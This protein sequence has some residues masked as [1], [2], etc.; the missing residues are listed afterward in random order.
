MSYE[1]KS[2][3]YYGGAFFQYRTLF[4]GFYLQAGARISQFVTVRRANF[5][6]GDGTSLLTK[7]R[8]EY[9]TGMKPLLGA[10]YRLNERYSVELNVGPLQLKN[11]DGVAKTGTLAE[12]SFLVHL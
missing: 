10:G 3:G 12:V 11:V 7:Y 2:D 1:D 5:L 4:E 9:A 6:P 8:G